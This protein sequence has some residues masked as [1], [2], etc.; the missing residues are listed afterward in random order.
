[1]LDQLPADELVQLGLLWVAK[2]AM[3]KC[4]SET[5]VVGFTEL[6]LAH[7]TFVDGY[8][9]LDFKPQIE[10][11][12]FTETVLSPVVCHHSDCFALGI[13]IQNS[14]DIYAGITRS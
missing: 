11:F 10:G 5:R 7:A 9:I 6:V 4:L 1:M 2:E 3:R 14:V 13:S 8:F 12:S